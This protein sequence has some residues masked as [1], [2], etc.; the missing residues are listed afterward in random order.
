MFASGL[1]IRRGHVALAFAVSISL[2]LSPLPPSPGLP[3][4]ESTAQSSTLINML[5]SQSDQSFLSNA[6]NSLT[7]LF[8]LFG[9]SQEA[10][11]QIPTPT[12]TPSLPLPTVSPPPVTD[13]PPEVREEIVSMRTENAKFFREPDG[14]KTAQFYPGPIHFLDSEGA[15]EE[16]DTTIVPSTR[17]GYAFRNRQGSFAVEFAAPGGSVDTVRVETGSEAI[18]F[19]PVGANPLSVPRA[20]GSRVTYPDAYPGVDLVYEVRNNG[21]KELLVLKERPQLPVSFRFLLGLGG[22]TAEQG[23]GEIS[24]TDGGGEV[25]FTIPPGWMEDAA[26]PDAASS[27][28]VA[29]QLSTQGGE[30]ALELTPDL[31]WLQDPA[32][33]YP[34]TIDPTLIHKANFDTYVD[35]GTPNTG[36]GSKQVIL[37]GRE[38]DGGSIRRG[39]LRFDSV[40]STLSGYSVL[41]AELRM[42]ATFHDTRVP[43]DTYWV[44]VQEAQGAWGAGVTWNS[45]PPASADIASQ[46]ACA[47]SWT[48]WD[49]TGSVTNWVHGTARNEGFRITAPEHTEYA[50]KRFAALEY[51]DQQDEAAPYLYIEWST[52]PST[53]TNLQPPSGTSSIDATPLLS[54]VHYDRDGDPGSLYF[55]VRRRSNGEI[56]D[57]GYGTPDPTASG[58]AAAFEADLRDNNGDF[59]CGETF[60]WAVDSDDGIDLSDQAWAAYSTMRPSSPTPMSPAEGATLNTFT[61]TFTAEEGAPNYQFV[62][63]S[64]SED[65]VRSP[66]LPTPT[67][68]V[69]EGVLADGGRYAWYVAP[70]E[71]VCGSVPRTFTLDVQR[72]GSRGY[73]PMVDSSLGHGTS[74]SVN[75]ANGNLVV[76]QTDASLPTVDD[77][78][79]V[80]RSYNSRAAG[81]LAYVED[82]LPYDAKIPASS[83]PW[84]W[85]NA[86][87][88][89]GSRSH[90]DPPKA[91]MH[92]HFFQGAQGRL[93][94]PQGSSIVTYAYLNPASA[95]REVM[96]QFHTP[97]RYDGDPIVWEHRAYWGE[98][99][100]G[101]GTNNTSSRQRIGDLPATG[102]WVR[103]EVPASAVGLEGQLIDGVAYTLY[104]GQAW[105]DKTYFGGGLSGY[106]WSFGNELVL[107]EL[108]FVR[109][110]ERTDNAHLELVDSYGGVRFY[111]QVGATNQYKSES[112]DF[113]TATKDTTAGEWELKNTEGFRYY[114]SLSDGNLTKIRP[115]E[116]G[117]STD[118]PAFSYLYSGG[119]LTGLKDRIN[120]QLSF[121]YDS[122]GR[123]SHVR[124]DFDAGRVIASYEY[125]QHDQLAAAIDANGHRTEYTY[126]PV[127]HDLLTITTPRG[128]ASPTVGDFTT[129]FAYQGRLPGEE[130]RRVQAV[131]RLHT[132]G[133]T[134]TQ[135]GPSFSYTPETRTTKVTSPRGNST[136]SNPSDFVTSFEYNERLNPVRITDP[137]GNA[138]VMEWNSENLRTRLVDREG[139]E[140]LFAYDGNGN[141]CRETLPASVL[142]IAGQRAK[143]EY[144]YD[145]FSGAYNCSPSTKPTYNLLTRTVDPEG[146][147]TKIEYW[148]PTA[149]KPWVQKETMGYGTPEAAS[150]SYTYYEDPNPSKA[151]R[152]GKVQTK[153]MPKGNAV[154]CDQ[155]CKDSYT[156]TYN[157]WGP[158]DLYS[159]PNDSDLV[160]VVQQGWLKSTSQPGD[161]PITCAGAAATACHHY[162]RRG[163]EIHTLDAKGDHYR[164]HDPDNRVVRSEDLGSTGAPD[165]ARWV[166]FSYDADGNL[167]RVIDPDIA[168][169][170]TAFSYDDLNRRATLVDAWG[171]TTAYKYDQNGNMVEKTT[172]G[173]GTTSYMYDG[174]DRLQS[175]TDPQ[176]NIT[177]YPVYDKEGRLLEKRL[178]NATHID[179]TYN[180]AGWLTSL[181]NRAGSTHTGAESSSSA[182]GDTAYSYDG[183]GKKRIEVLPGSAGTRTYQYDAVGRLKAVVH[184]TTTRD[185]IYD[186]NSNR[187]ELRVNGASTETYTY[188]ALDQLTEVTEGAAIQSFT[189]NTAGEVTT[190]VLPGYVS[191]S[192][193]RSGTVDSGV[194]PGYQSW[195][196][197][198]TA[199]G[200]IEAT[201]NWSGSADLNLELRKIDGNTTI[202]KAQAAN[203]QP[204]SLTFDV[205]GS[206]TGEYSL[207][208][209]AVS[210]QANYALSYSYP[211]SKQRT[212]TYDAGGI[213]ITEDNN[214]SSTTY[215]VDGLSRVI[216]RTERTFEGAV[217]SD[218]KYGFDNS[219]DSRSAEIH[220]TNGSVLATF[221]SDPEGLLAVRRNAAAAYQYY[222]DHGDLIQT[223]D[224]SG[225]PAIPTPMIY[226]EFGRRTDGPYPYG[227]SGRQQ[228]DTSEL[229]GT[230]RMGVRLYDPSLGRFLSKDPVEGGCANDYSFVWA[231]PVNASDLDGRV[232]LENSPRVGPCHQRKATDPRRVATIKTLQSPQGKL[233]FELKLGLEAQLRLPGPL[234][235]N[236]QI[237]VNGKYR[238]NYHKSGRGPGY[239]Y[240][241][242]V[243]GPFKAGD[244]ITFKFRGWE[245][246]DPGGGFW[247]EYSCRW[248]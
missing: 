183:S 194:S 68:T 49:V 220:A 69:P 82:Q 157:Y 130:Y 131:K 33:V 39:L 173:I 13:P 60:D 110:I 121:T 72:L 142:N 238:S 66:V 126:D 150:T 202:L 91:G 12:P 167:T 171:R 151:Y 34:V 180:A 196:F 19:T 199:G 85:D 208:V 27:N 181:N 97:E 234:E 168:G 225:T 163:S 40:G 103:L 211:V 175:L 90:T 111:Y 248:I 15:W 232:P 84:V 213:P 5:E 107:S 144:F 207:R 48:K 206:D 122:E 75:A 221:V 21:L 14:K 79:V 141:L 6:W 224:A 62:I 158:S 105:F 245:L 155:A 106:G 210:G 201:L 217:T 83:D 118:P 87:K 54:A 2:V 214:E 205:P 31:T 239:S 203:G 100:L 137:A 30:T 45:Q 55:E 233:W 109:L 159:F 11:A 29:V 185:Y 172:T 89:S 102:A 17:P 169:D 227:W 26:D 192:K 156:T 117:K 80:S 46:P 58:Q 104:D 134:T 116:L 67:W 47:G 198:V 24:L 216:R 128:T 162:D 165:P 147:V 42:H 78:F 50:R 113:A 92:Q 139:N 235:V 119:R 133:G 244:V 186:K 63:R 112:G 53:P 52:P 215:V 35:S 32:R 228:R 76:S 7:G 8:R 132:E 18:R 77:P 193:T 125:D 195:R 57:G 95:P 129:S 56:V 20:E 59:I 229:T 4:G 99:L 10:S 154:G 51:P 230:I 16:I 188:N 191:R 247:R 237:F 149:G 222:N 226:D 37:V 93:F 190:H 3:G 182:L 246:A 148:T 212:Y 108:S 28:D 65:V 184:D 136:P 209:I 189:Y 179:Y 1:R 231:D 98:D 114:F 25:L 241:G 204:E 145:E 138:T 44:K 23:G 94:I 197:D 135:L 22:L 240:H 242:T 101:W 123:L 71:G 152:Y 88:W 218:I 200:P 243:P 178:P 143:T 146:R 170:Q 219:G 187:V 174:L 38:S 236:A 120:R 9:G 81:K 73:Y 61:P 140:W 124:S 86:V 64:G 43:C 96:L 70:G 176:G 115:P 160:N 36:N 41:Y 177:T 127:T 166:Q 164:V 223:A 74:A 153:T 161:T